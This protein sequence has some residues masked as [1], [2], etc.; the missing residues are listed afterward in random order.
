MGTFL[1][2]YCNFSKLIGVCVCV[3]V[4]VFVCVCVCV[5]VFVHTYVIVHVWPY[6]G[7]GEGAEHIPVLLCV[8][9]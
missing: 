4:C 7:V 5:C 3:C 6:W 1:G 8:Y 2:P 9:I